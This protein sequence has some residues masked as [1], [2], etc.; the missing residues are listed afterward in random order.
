MKHKNQFQNILQLFH[1]F[2]YDLFN[3]AAA[4]QLIR[5]MP[6][7]L[8]KNKLKQMCNVAGHSLIFRH[9]LKICLE[10][11]IETQSTPIRIAGNF[12]LPSPE[13]EPTVATTIIEWNFRVL[14]LRSSEFRTERFKV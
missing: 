9:Y 5:L 11:L 14:V 6:R 7:R 4:E 3:D 13:N 2:I 8:M 12:N 10:K 1:V